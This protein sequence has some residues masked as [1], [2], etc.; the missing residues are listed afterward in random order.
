MNVE[1]FDKA[2]DFIASRDDNQL[3]LSE[4]QRGKR[5]KI[6]THSS[7]ATCGTIACA[8]GWLALNPEFEALGLQ[9]GFTGAPR[10]GSLD[11]EL[12]GYGALAKL[13]EL[14]YRVATNL[15]YFRQY[16]DIELFGGEACNLMTDRQL[17]LSR[18]RV[19]RAEY[20]PALEAPKPKAPSKKYRNKPVEVEA[21]T[22]ED[23]LAE[24]RKNSTYSVN[25]VPWSFAFKGYP[26][27][28]ERDDCYLIRMGKK[29]SVL[30]EN[31]ILV[32]SLGDAFVCSR[33]DFA[34]A[35]ER[36]ME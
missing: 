13:F 3:D 21:F 6:A 18:A 36:I 7:Q 4:W 15:F 31:Q 5:G 12:S 33:E 30:D 17:W 11:G 26:V 19:V 20:G 34:E 9:P 22:F 32:L 16:E 2:V 28:H 25:G 24:G 8:G 35:Y 14:T 23:V 10:F 27:T 1:L 29:T